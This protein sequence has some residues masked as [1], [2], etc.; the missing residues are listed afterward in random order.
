MEQRPVRITA[1]EHNG[2]IYIVE[3]ATGSSAKESAYEKVRRLILEDTKNHL[4]KSA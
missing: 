3:Y 2:T 4:G 1:G